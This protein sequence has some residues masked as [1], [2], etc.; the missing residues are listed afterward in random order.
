MWVFKYFVKEGLS[1][2][3]KIQNG[4]WY[5]VN[6]ISR[7]QI[8]SCTIIFSYILL[9]HLSINVS[10]NWRFWSITKLNCYS[11]FTTKISIRYTMIEFR[12][13][14]ISMHHI[15]G[16]SSSRSLLRWITK[17][18]FFFVENKN[19]PTTLIDASQWWRLFARS[20]EG[21]RGAKIALLAIMYRCIYRRGSLG[22]NTI[23]RF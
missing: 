23:G 18:W 13:L 1:I 10:G 12:I 20:I 8:C 17:M 19:F 14:I 11:E 7:F 2:F 5:A 16:V 15:C 4:G 6:G 21:K 22:G 9:T 3:K